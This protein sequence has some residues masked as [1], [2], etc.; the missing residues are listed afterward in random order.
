MPRQQSLLS[1]SDATNPKDNPPQ[2]ATINADDALLAALGY[3]QEFKREFTALEV[4]LP[5]RSWLS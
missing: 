2:E 1:S 4:R 5:F 3:K